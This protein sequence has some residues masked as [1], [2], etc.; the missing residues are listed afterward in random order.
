M[1]V[2][3]KARP[4]NRQYVVQASQIGAG[5]QVV[6][7]VLPLLDLWI[8]GSVER[9][10][11][12]AYPA[13]GPGEI[14]GDRNAIVVYLVTVGV[15]GLLGWLATLW[16]AQRGR[17]VRTIVTTLFALGMTTLII[18]AGVGGEAY[19]QIVPLWLGLTLLF[20]PVLPGIA[21]L[22]AAWSRR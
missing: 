20:I 6:C 8:F 13:W 1:D 7:I 5:L 18:T 14:A 15:L 12:T 3:N 10:V 11:E 17:G 21:A 16:A 4:G 19:E 9:N 2:R 22:L